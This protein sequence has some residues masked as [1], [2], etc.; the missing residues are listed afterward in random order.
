MSL[1][2]PR[3][4]CRG[5][6]SIRIRRGVRGAGARARRTWSRAHVASRRRRGHA[7]ELAVF[8]ALIATVGAFHVWWGGTASPGRP[9]ASALL[10]FGG[11]IAIFYA[12]ASRRARVAAHALLALSLAIA[13]VMIAAQNGALLR[14]DRDG[15]AVMID[16]LSPTSPV[17]S[18]FPSF[19]IGGLARAWTR[20]LAWLAMGALVIGR[21][22]CGSGRRWRVRA[23]GVPLTRW[24]RRTRRALCRTGPAD[25]D[26]RADSVARSLDASRRPIG[27][28]LIRSRAR[29][30]CVVRRAILSRAPA[31]APRISRS[32]FWKA[33]GASAGEHSVVHPAHREPR[34]R[35]PA[36][37]G[38]RARRDVAQTRERRTSPRA[39]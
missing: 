23:D 24:R 38:W 35:C 39:G 8:G 11:P 7:L 16:W 37:W 19:I 27:I 1:R 4:D 10:L 12:G 14:N 22:A 20:A 26:A 33:I 17:T 34:R 18:A 32:I 30:G 6:S 15:S 28:V 3:T 13:V 9:V 21:L 25:I 2:N 31:S 29:A 5:R 36:I